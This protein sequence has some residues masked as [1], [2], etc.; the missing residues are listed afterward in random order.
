[1]SKRPGDPGYAGG[2]CIH[3]RPSKIGA[4]N[5]HDDCEAGVLHS[6][7]DGVPF[8]KR[9]CFLEQKTG[10]SKPD[11][12]TCEHLRRPTREEIAAHEG[13]VKTRFDQ[14]G[15]VMSGIRPW[16]DAHKGQPAAEVVEC[17][18]CKGRLHLSIARNG[19]VHGRCETAGCVSWME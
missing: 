18:A 1:M 3:Y 2:W 17:P 9:P 12:I 5:G 14:F 16:R 8:A 11:A 19:H 13:W 4:V 10:A 15:T 7:F 6:T